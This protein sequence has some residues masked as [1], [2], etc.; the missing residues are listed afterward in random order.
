MLLTFSALGVVAGVLTTVSGQGGGLFLLLAVSSVLGPHAALA[1]TAPALLFGNAHRAFLLR[2]AVDRA[3]AFRVMAGAVPGAIA[4]G[5]LVGWAPPSLLKLAMVVMTALAVA[6]AARVISF[7]VP[8]AALAP[9]GVV[10]GAMT[11]AGGGAGVLFSP[12][13]LSL[14]LT[15]AAFVGTASAI[16]FATHVGRVLAY[17]EAGLFSWELAQITVTLTLAIFA[18]NALGERVRAR[19]S[20]SLATRLEY[21][22]LVV[23][24]LMS[25]AGLS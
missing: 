6:K 5:L 2:H 4:G 18:G 24:V 1:A 14:G 12:M 11:G 22:T 19:L 8:R 23:C 17:A 20:S 15:G 21:A 16:A 25:L 10:V 9:A 13:L 3:I 7:G